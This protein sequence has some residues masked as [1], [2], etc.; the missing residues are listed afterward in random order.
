[1]PVLVSL[2]HTAL[3]FRNTTAGVSFLLLIIL[4]FSAHA[5]FA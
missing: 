1:V 5:Y 2:N 3:V 4:I